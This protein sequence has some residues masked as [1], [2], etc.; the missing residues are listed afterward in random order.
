MYYPFLS[1]S[2][3]SLAAGRKSF[4]PKLTGSIFYAE[5][6]STFNSFAQGMAA[7]LDACGKPCR[8]GR[9][10]RNNAAVRNTK[11]FAY[12]KVGHCKPWC[13]VAMWL[14]FLRHSTIKLTY[15]WATRQLSLLCNWAIMPVVMSDAAL[16]DTHCHIH[17]AW[18]SVNGPDATA[19]LWDKAGRPDADDIIARA[20]EADVTKMICVGTTLPD[21]Q[22]AIEFVKDRPHTWASIGIHPHESKDYAD[23]P[24][25]LKTFT[26]LA[27]KPKVIA[28]GECGLDFYYTHSSKADQQKLLRFQIELALEHDLPMI[29]H[30]RDAFDDFWPIFDSYT[31]IRGVVHSF[32]ATE[33]ELEQ[34]LQRDLY[35]G[36]NGIMTFTR[37]PE[38]IAAA[39][40]VPLHRLLLETDAPF[41]T[42]HPYR[43]SICEPKHVRTTCEHLAGLRGETVEE[44]SKQTNANVRN[45]FNL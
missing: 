18:R 28:V 35:V 21:S 38:Q 22:L 41:L 8:H 13:S 2:H 12:G 1:G 5:E 14:A 44:M 39:K 23:Q 43:G 26:A 25:K 34:I 24:A 36:L 11:R 7:F 4:A 27:D 30:V 16:T 6:R 10:I 42:P 45:L 40:A 15:L 31:G 9:H 17:E 37:N 32:S 29:F 33:K 19:K 3:K 20:L